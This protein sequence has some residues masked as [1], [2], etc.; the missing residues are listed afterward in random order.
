MNDVNSIWI[1][2]DGPVWEDLESRTKLLEDLLRDGRNV[3]EPHQVRLAT[4]E[5]GQVIPGKFEVKFQKT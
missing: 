2:V 5:N 3:I 4:D 1:E